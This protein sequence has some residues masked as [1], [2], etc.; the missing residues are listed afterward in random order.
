MDKSESQTNPVPSDLAP[1][2][3]AITFSVKDIGNAIMP[4]KSL[5]GHD[6]IHTNQLINTGPCFSNLLCRLTNK[7]ISYGFLPHSM[8]LAKI[9]PTVK[10]SVGN[11][12]SSSNYRPAMISSNLLKMFKYLTLPHLEKK[13]LNLSHNQIAYRPSTGCL[14]AITLLKEAT[15]HYNLKHSDVF[16][17][18]IDLSKAYNRI[19]V[20][21]ICPNFRRTELPAQITDINE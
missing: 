1:N 3:S 18:M 7:F 21:T 11:K 9:R 14:K 16:C 8:L 12:V 17:A 15:S 13:Y 6:D 5:N 19:N 20:N 10:N 2:T 4:L